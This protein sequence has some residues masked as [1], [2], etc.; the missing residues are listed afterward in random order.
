[1]SGGAKN[2]D[3]LVNDPAART[4]EFVFRLLTQHAPL[5][6]RRNEDE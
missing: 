5:D 1:M 6:N 3:E 2:G 4:D